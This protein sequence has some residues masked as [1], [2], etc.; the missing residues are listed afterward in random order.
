MIRNERLL[1]EVAHIIIELAHE[2]G[3]DCASSF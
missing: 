2:G 1:K 3:F